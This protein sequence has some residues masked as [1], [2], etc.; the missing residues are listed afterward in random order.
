MT[1][2]GALNASSKESSTDR[3]ATI[4]EDG[5][6]L[7]IGHRT[8][9]DNDGYSS[10]FPCFDIT[11][12]KR[13]RTASP[14]TT[15][16][17]STDAITATFIQ[18]LT[19]AAF[20]LHT[21]DSMEGEA[22]GVPLSEQAMEDYPKD[23]V[24]RQAYTGGK[25][26]DDIR[27]DILEEDIVAD[28][29][30]MP[31]QKSTS[32]TRMLKLHAGGKL[33]S[34][35][36]RTGPGI[37]KS[38]AKRKVKGGGSVALQKI[39]VMKYGGESSSPQG[40]A[41]K[42]KDILEDKLIFERSSIKITEAP[43]E[44]K[45]K[46]PSKPM[47]PFFVSKANHS[48]EE[49]P[50]VKGDSVRLDVDGDKPKLESSMSPSQK[51][52][53]MSAKGADAWAKIG[54]ISGRLGN[55]ADTRVLK[56]PGS[57]EPLWPPRDMLHCRS[58]SSSATNNFYYRKSNL[59]PS[60]YKKH[61]GLETQISNQEEMLYAYQEHCSSLRTAR[62]HGTMD[63]RIL[64]TLRKP[65]RRL[66][67]GKTLQDTLRSHIACRLPSND[68]TSQRIVSK[69]KEHLSPFASSTHVSSMTHNALADIFHKLPTSLT[70]FD[71]FQCET[72]DWV[73]KYA[74]RCAADV[75]QH[76]REAL[77]LRDW[78]LNSAVTAVTIGNSNKSTTSEPSL[79]LRR[80]AVRLKRKRQKEGKLD[81]FIVSSDD[82]A[83]DMDELTDPDETLPSHGNAL[84]P[85]KSMIRT[86][87]DPRLSGESSKLNNAVVISGPHGCGKTAAV[88]AVA[89]ELGFEVFEINAGSRRSG[90]DLLD[91]VGDMTRNHL[92]HQT[93][94]TDKAQTDDVTCDDSIVKREI[95]MTRQRTVQSFFKQ[96]PTSK[97]S[98]KPLPAASK[99]HSHHHQP[100]KE[101]KPRKQQQQSLILLDE[102]D[103]L[104]EEDKQF[105]ATTLGLIIQSKRPIVMTCTD[106]SRLPIEEMV[107]HAIFRFSPPPE[108]IAVDYL[109]LLAGNEGH[110]ISRNAISALYAAKHADLRASISELNFWCQMAVGDRKGGVEWMLDRSN[111]QKSIDQ[112]GEILRVVSD[113]TYL[114][115]MGSLER[116]NMDNKAMGST[117]TNLESSTQTL[118]DWELDMADLDRLIDLGD[119]FSP[120]YQPLSHQ[121]LQTL[122]NFDLALDAISL[123]DTFPGLGLRQDYTVIS[124]SNI[125]R[126]S[127]NIRRLGSILL[128]RI[129]LRRLTLITL[130]EYDCFRQS[131]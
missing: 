61:K 84:L 98:S 28:R 48:S 118:S 51:P 50:F 72:Q 10:D 85:K 24:S 92:V 49:D 22:T 129:S 71:R 37:S 120:A 130:K 111:P 60:Y 13:R 44:P 124:L 104:F 87:D 39:V 20:G 25:D 105:W 102:V 66:M 94:E 53:S 3:T 90:K 6:L 73:H 89:Q 115:G 126:V 12:R 119:L 110:I 47:H 112:G 19:A 42:I 116:I 100:P 17:L 122:K 29:L 83:N 1:P 32:N 41:E 27:S 56:I 30:H 79:F 99:L 69:Q 64:G 81:G 35:G 86:S 40:T 14:T 2:D 101:Q 11:R 67:T 107:L 75:L 68:E 91:R 97:Q 117:A 63:I 55:A 78:L 114:E 96:K 108:H 38:R 125:R 58:L 121:N 123:A 45:P 33:A 93:A 36:T 31:T 82:E 74:P 76:G 34:P 106:E 70:A 23:G 59:L 18:Q 77:L 62:I 5:T 9:L 16:L 65:C 46:Q 15:S 21:P 113:S 103:I 52:S 43:H 127:A 26:L 109:I 128:S 7:H 57:T 80:S 54:E 88:Y 131:Q 95:D 8:P 4:A